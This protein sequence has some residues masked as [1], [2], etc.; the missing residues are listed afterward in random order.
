M[1]L[2]FKCLIFMLFFSS[3]LLATKHTSQLP[4]TKCEELIALC[5]PILQEWFAQEQKNDP[6]LHIMTSY[7]KPREQN[8]AYRS[9]ASKVMWGK[10]AHNYIPCFAI[11]LFF[12]VDGKSTQ[13]IPKYKIMINRLPSTIANGS[14]FES[15]VDWSHFYVKNWQELAKNYPYGTIRLSH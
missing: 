14:T 3:T 12:L 4:C 1:P 8:Q 13:N 10:S 15:L 11:D 6:T 5:H 7:R 9:H 2:F